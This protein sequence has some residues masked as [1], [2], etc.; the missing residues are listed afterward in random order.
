MKKS[1]VLGKINRAVAEK[2]G[3]LAAGI[4]TVDKR[5]VS[6]VDKVTPVKE[7]D[8]ES[9]SKL[10]E[11]GESRD[12]MLRKVKDLKRQAALVE[13]RVPLVAFKNEDEM[14]QL[15][16]FILKYYQPILS[17]YEENTLKNITSMNYQE[18]FTEVKKYY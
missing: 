12:D 13:K 14:Q 8:P 16:F 18:E 3:Q 2:I 11:I 6:F 15:K 10:I 5:T 1:G 17:V 7:V 4:S 9:P